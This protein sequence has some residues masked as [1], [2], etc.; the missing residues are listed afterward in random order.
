MVNIEKISNLLI[1]VAKDNPKVEKLILFGSRA[2]GIERQGS[3][4]D[5]AVVSPDMTFG[6]FL[7]LLSKVDD[8]DV[9][10]MVD[11]VKF[12]T[13][14]DKLKEEILKHGI[15]IYQRAEKC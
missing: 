2:K 4:I 13:V 1:E 10:V 6:E 12:E 8:L 3:D 15:V 14:N 9:P 5:I 7:R 11:L